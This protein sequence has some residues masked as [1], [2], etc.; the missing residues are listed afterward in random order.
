MRYDEEKLWTAV[1]ERA[2]KD[3]VGKNVKLKE[4]AIK[5][6]NSESFE[7]VCELAN[8]DFQYIKKHCFDILERKK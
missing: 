3:A 5:W 1:I 7:T 6:L 4:E 8:L 2:M